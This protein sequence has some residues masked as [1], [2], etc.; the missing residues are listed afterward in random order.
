MSLRVFLTGG[1]GY[2]GTAVLDAALKAGHRVSAI[3]RDPE[4]VDRLNVMGATGI[5]AELATPKRYLDA[6]RRADVVI[7]TALEDSP[8]GPQVDRTFLEQVIPV[9]SA[10][11]RPAKLIYTSGIWV[12]GNTHAPADETAPLDPAEISAWR[13]EHERLVL[14]SATSSLQAVVVRPGIVYGDGRG[15]IADL[16]KDALNGLVRVVGSG[17]N[18]WPCVYDRD[19]ADLYVRLVQLPGASGIYHATDEGDERVID[20]VDGIAGHLSQRPDV[21]HVGIDEARAQMGPYADALA[22]DQVLRSPRA[23]ALGWTPT[24]RSVADNVARLFEEYRSAQRS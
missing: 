19:L 4:K 11:E 17:Q 10:N 24:L 12:L 5:L 6:V 23:R 18:H 8:R 22:L 21:R 3:A 14:E 1:T 9:L 2:I 7:H 20:I 15:I 13:V 16:L